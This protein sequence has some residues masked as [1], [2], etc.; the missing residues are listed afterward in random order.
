M[1]HATVRRATARGSAYHLARL[2]YT[3]KPEDGVSDSVTVDYR[4]ALS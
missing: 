4:P 3:V 2:S 1:G